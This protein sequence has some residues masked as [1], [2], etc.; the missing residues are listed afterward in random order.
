LPSVDESGNI[1]WTLSENT[2]GT[3]PATPATANIRG[4]IGLTGSAVNAVTLSGTF[5]GDSLAYNLYNVTRAG[6]GAN[7]G[8]FSVRNG[9]TGAAA[10]FGAITASATALATD[11]A[12]TASVTSGGTNTAKTFAF[13]FG[14]PRGANGYTYTPSLNTSNY[15][16]F[17]PSI[18][19]TEPASYNTSMQFS[20][21][22]YVTDMGGATASSSNP[23]T[24]GAVYNYLHNTTAEAHLSGD[25][26]TSATVTA[27]ASG[28]NFSFNI[29]RG[30]TE[31]TAAEIQNNLDT[32]VTRAKDAEATTNTSLSNH[33]SDVSNPHQVTKEQV[34]LGNVDNTSDADKPVSTY[35]QAAIN[36][37]YTLPH[38]IIDA[39]GYICVNYG[40]GR[41]ITID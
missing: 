9:A 21:E 3:A 23:I 15:L 16:I 41:D 17:T 24:A 26:G 22:A 29:P 2:T 8:T 31:E 14:L 34:G 40:S 39:E 11:C 13:N 1:S 38:L 12:A 35:Q 32:E 28:L 4:P 20:A 36:V 27:T 10:G 33:M 6:D 25:S 7:I 30:L 5:N 37:F 18:Q 19:K